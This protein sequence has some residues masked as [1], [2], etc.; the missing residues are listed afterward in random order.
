MKA[1]EAKPEHP[2]LDFHQGGYWVKGTR[3]SLDSIIY[4][5][6]EGL[7]PETIQRECFPVLSLRHVYGALTYYLEHQAELDAYLLQAE[8][9]EEVVRQQV[10]EAY[11]KG[12]QAVDRLAAQLT[13]APDE[14]QVP[15]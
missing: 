13:Q 15:S 1:E 14:N 4:R 3:A 11:P 8:E 7:S 2:Y 10:R 9:E 5:W 6:R 12:A